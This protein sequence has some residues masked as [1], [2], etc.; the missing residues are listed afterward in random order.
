MKAMVSTVCAL[1]LLSVLAA[2]TATA[3]TGAPTN[4]SKT[5]QHPV[6][7][8]EPIKHLAIKHQ[9]IKHIAQHAGGGGSGGQ[10]G[11]SGGQAAQGDAKDLTGPKPGQYLPK[12]GQSKP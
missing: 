11:S 8:H 1:G 9:P 5:T 4:S 6:I 10:S 7:K 3:E 2:G 12:N